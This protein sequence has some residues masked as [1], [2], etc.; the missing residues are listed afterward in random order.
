MKAH[1]APDGLS[2]TF[3]KIM[4]C[5]ESST[6]SSPAKYSVGG[7]ALA[8]YMMGRPNGLWTWHPEDF[9]VHVA[10]FGDFE[11][12]FQRVSEAFMSYQDVTISVLRTSR[13]LG[14]DTSQVTEN[15][16]KV[17]FPVLDMQGSFIG[18]KGFVLRHVADLTVPLRYSSTALCN[19]IIVWTINTTSIYSLYPGLLTMKKVNKFC[20]MLDLSGT[21][22]CVALGPHELS[23]IVRFISIGVRTVLYW[24]YNWPGCDT[25]SCP[26]VERVLGDCFTFHTSMSGTGMRY[27]R[28]RN[29]D[30][31]MYQN[32][33]HWDKICE[34]Y[35]DKTGSPTCRISAGACS[36]HDDMSKLKVNGPET[37]MNTPAN[38]LAHVFDF[39][40]HQKIELELRNGRQPPKF[41][42]PDGFISLIYNMHKARASNPAADTTNL[43]LNVEETVH[44]DVLMMDNRT[45]TGQSQHGTG[46][47]ITLRGLESDWNPQPL[48]FTGYQLP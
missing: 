14:L 47:G 41:F 36:S 45:S 1:M 11:A 16:I 27:Y 10:D 23:S 46:S 6:N 37:F 26:R 15:D 43:V 33:L 5:L 48:S 29:I 30:W 20:P 32:P 3:D 12:T 9:V 13:P 7:V 4:S 40:V 2:Q 8:Y 21:G 34:S 39:M 28:W 17:S 31:A 44:S 24:K 19:A 35:I 42:D 38:A 22:Q 25:S 18:R